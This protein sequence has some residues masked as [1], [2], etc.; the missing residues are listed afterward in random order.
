MITCNSGGT[1]PGCIFARRI[2]F[3]GICLSLWHREHSALPDDWSYLTVVILE[4]FLH[5][6][7]MC[8]LAILL[9]L[10]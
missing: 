9:T 7:N 2:H 6:L 3:I 5:K 8:S 4:T 1:D 10:E